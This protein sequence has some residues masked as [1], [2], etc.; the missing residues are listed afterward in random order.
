[1]HS[2]K[3][4]L[5]QSSLTILIYLLKLNTNNK[6]KKKPSY[7]KILKLFQILMQRKQIK[8]KLEYIKNNN[9]K[10]SM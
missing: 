7:L 3:V 1:M 4:G 5:E 10:D 6:N 8:L 9:I 2:R